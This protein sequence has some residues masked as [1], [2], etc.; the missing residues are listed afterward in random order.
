MLVNYEVNLTYIIENFCE[1]KNAP[2]LKCEGKCHLKKELKKEQRKQ[3]DTP[4]STSEV[5]NIV[6]SVHKTPSIDFLLCERSE[7][8][9]NDFYLLLDYNSV[10]T[11]VFHPPQFG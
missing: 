2:E 6:L 3:E 10:L 1:N 8:S 5:L 7:A 9:L 11:S 4:A